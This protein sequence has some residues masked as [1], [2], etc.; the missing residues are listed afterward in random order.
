M[1]HT[2]KRLGFCEVTQD[3][4]DEGCLRLHQLPTAEQAEVLR[5]ILGIRKW[6][7]LAPE[8]LERLRAGAAA[9]NGLEPQ[10]KAETDA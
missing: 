4:D 10:E 2:K 9:W 7:E 3:G 1:T 5:D 6:V 8:T